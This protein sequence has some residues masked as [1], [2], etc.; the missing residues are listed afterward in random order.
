[1]KVLGCGD[2]HTAFANVQVQKFIHIRLVFQQN[3][4]AGHTDIR[5]TVFHIDGNIGG[6]YP[7]VANAALV[8]FK[9]Q[10]AVIR[11]L[12]KAGICPYSCEV[13]IQFTISIRHLIKTLHRKKNELCIHKKRDR[14]RRNY[15]LIDTNKTVKR[16][17][18]DSS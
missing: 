8:V 16:W 2:C 17:Y 13:P 5:H 10:L 1:M 18:L 12:R 7:K 15:A 3:I 6:F 9:N 14:E 4:L 11:K